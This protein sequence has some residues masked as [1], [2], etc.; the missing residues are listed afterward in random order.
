M[1]IKKVRKLVVIS[2]AILAIAFGI[3]FAFLPG[4]AAGWPI[5][6][7]ANYLLIAAHWWLLTKV[8]CA[9]LSN[10]RAMTVL[11]GMISFFPLALAFA[12]CF[13]AGKIDRTLMMPAG[14]GIV[15]VPLAVTLYCVFA[16][17]KSLLH[18]H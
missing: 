2:G 1:N 7:L 18:R 5:F 12:L 9:L 11:L 16:G 8:I 13:V 4:F 3:P 17:L 15:T 10:E 6:L 14:A